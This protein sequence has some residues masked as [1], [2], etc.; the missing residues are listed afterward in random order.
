MTTKTTQFNQEDDF[1]SK[2]ALEQYF[3]AIQQRFVDIDERFDQVD[4]R[5]NQ[6]DQRFSGLEDGMERGFNKING[7]LTA[8]LEIFQDNE[9]ETK[10]TL[11]DHEKRINSLEKRLS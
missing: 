1:M 2:E 8:V 9:K 6:I 5:F 3:T 7:A 10:K 4:Q 11:W